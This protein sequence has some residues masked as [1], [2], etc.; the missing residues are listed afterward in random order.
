MIFAHADPLFHLHITPFTAWVTLLVIGVAVF[1]LLGL[2]LGDR[3]E[4]VRVTREA[5]MLRALV[6]IQAAEPDQ[7]TE[8]LEAWRN[9]AHAQKQKGEINL[10]GFET[11]QS[12]LIQRP[13]YLASAYEAAYL[14][15]IISEGTKTPTPS[16]ITV[17]EL[18]RTGISREKAIRIV[19]EDRL[20]LA[21]ALY[22][23]LNEM[24]HLAHADLSDVWCM[25]LA[26]QVMTISNHAKA[27][28]KAKADSLS[29][30]VEQ[31]SQLSGVPLSPVVAQPSTNI[32]ADMV[33]KGI[34][35]HG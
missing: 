12:Q 2:W 9:L 35:P 10:F 3:S 20:T 26:D 8:A 11:K 6:K 15:D 27:R 1:W 25:S 19:D 16:Q 32:H 28:R 31:L 4:K 22:E 14:I 24:L 29:A 5:E 23:H 17:K 34:G 18:L 33:Q 7:L 30:D 13:S 21:I